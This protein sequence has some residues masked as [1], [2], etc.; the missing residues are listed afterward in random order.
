[1]AEEFNSVWTALEDNAVLAENLRLR[2]QLMA[3]VSDYVKQ[4]G[5]TPADAAAR[6]GTTQ[7]RLND[8]LTGRIEKCTIDRLVNMLATAGFKISM[9]IDHTP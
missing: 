3:E 1:M 4:T 9:Q 5:L 2:A 7:P 8:V 6:L